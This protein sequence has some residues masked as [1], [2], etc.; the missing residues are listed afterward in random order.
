MEFADERET[1]LSR[2]GRTIAYLAALGDKFPVALRDVPL[3]RNPSLRINEAIGKSG[4]QC[5]RSRTRNRTGTHERGRRNGLRA[6][7]CGSYGNGCLYVASSRSKCSMRALSSIIFSS[8]PTMT[9]L[10]F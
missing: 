6:V 9:S 3:F 2:L 10:N 8:R 4:L 5:G 1:S 7:V